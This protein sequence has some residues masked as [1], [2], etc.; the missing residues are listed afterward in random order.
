MITASLAGIGANPEDLNGS[1]ASAGGDIVIRSGGDIDLRSGS[2]LATPESILTLSPVRSGTVLIDAQGNIDFTGEDDRATSNAIRSG[3]LT[4]RAGGS[5]NLDLSVEDTGIYTIGDNVTFTA[6]N[7]IRLGNALILTGLDA[8]QNTLSPTGNVSLSS[9]NGGIFIDQSITTGNLIGDSG[10]VTIEA[11]TEIQAGD[12]DTSSLISNAGDV[13]LDPIGDIQVSSINTT[14]PNG[15]GGTIDITA[16]QSFRATDSFTDFNG[17]NASIS[18][19]GSSGNGPIT[20]RHGG[21]GFIPFIV[22][23]ASLNGTQ[24]AI[25][26]GSNTI[27]P[28]QAFFA[29]IL[30]GDIQIITSPQQESLIDIEDISINVD[31]AAIYSESDDAVK[32]AFVTVIS[33]DIDKIETV[34]ETVEDKFQ[35]QYESYYGNSLEPESNIAA[36]PQAEQNFA[37]PVTDFESPTDDVS[38]ESSE[39]ETTTLESLPANDTISGDS[40]VIINRQTTPSERTNPNSLSEPS[41]DTPQSVSEQES[42]SSEGN[43]LE[44]TTYSE[45]NTDPAES[46]LDQALIDTPNDSLGDNEPEETSPNNDLTVSDDSELALVVDPLGGIIIESSSSQNQTTESDDSQG[47][48]EVSN[49]GTD[50]KESTVTEAQNTIRRIESQTGAKPAIVYAFFAPGDQLTQPVTPS[51]NI[52]E[53]AIS[54]Q[55]ASK[56]EVLWAFNANDSLPLL[57]S[58]SVN[59]KVNQSVFLPQRPWSQYFSAFL[60][61]SAYK[62]WPSWLQ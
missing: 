58:Q 15:A 10:D 47:T 41:S 49:G 57:I 43:S 59:N 11:L 56:E 54:Q 26:T 55:L 9:S 28:T 24:A 60:R 6:N 18:S 23:D 22:G 13:L 20:I 8:P 44:Q 17:I 2:V 33:D 50:E 12:I 53:D 52:P 30:Q 45:E 29:P 25:T 46:I 32:P 61:P 39:L 35:E 40:E 36:S 48:A 16:G 38:N 34:L 1:T 3:D 21:N 31:E 19:A 51:G 4:F 27:L 62:I 42:T 37:Q 7:D 14:A 5:I